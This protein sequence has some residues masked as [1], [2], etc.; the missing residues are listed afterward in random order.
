MVDAWITGVGDGLLVFTF[1]LGTRLVF[2][3]KS[4]SLFVCSA[5]V[6]IGSISGAILVAEALMGVPVSDHLGGVISNTVVAASVYGVIGILAYNLALQLDLPLA[7]VLALVIFFVVILVYIES[8]GPLVGFLFAVACD[9]VDR[10]KQ[11]RIAINLSA[12]F[13]IL[14][15]LCLLV[16]LCFVKN[17]GPSKGDG[18]LFIVGGSVEQTRVLPKAVYGSSDPGNIRFGESGQIILENEFIDAIGMVWP[19]FSI[20]SNRY[21]LRLRARSNGKTK[22]GLYVRIQELDENANGRPVSQFAAGGESGII[23]ASRQ[24]IHMAENLEL[25][26]NWR[27]FEFEYVP[28]RSAKSASILILNYEEMGNVPLEVALLSYRTSES[29]LLFIGDKLGLGFL[30]LEEKVLDSSPP[31]YK[32]LSSRN[33][34][35]AEVVDRIIPRKLLGGLGLGADEPIQSANGLQHNHPHSLFF[36]T[37]YF[38]GFIGLGL[39]IVFLI[40]LVYETQ[41]RNF[42]AKLGSVLL[43]FALACLSVDGGMILDKNFYIWIVLWLPISILFSAQKFNDCVTVQ[44]SVVGE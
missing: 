30:P 1:I 18:E 39:L 32:Q 24:V 20:T 28:T 35:W 31:Y 44:S 26:A 2:S 40:T 9:F 12:V 8:F 4:T 7:G 43:L 19:S 29:W 15:N 23:E 13:L 6:I 11:T 34:I 14:A 27:D 25:S 22:G 36:G 3:A 5:V 21:I 38:G 33:S 17:A 37:L 10:R 42:N 41:E 16:G